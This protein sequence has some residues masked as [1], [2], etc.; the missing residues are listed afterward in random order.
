[1]KKILIVFLFSFFALGVTTTQ[2]QAVKKTTHAVKK[3]AKKVGNKTAELASK[4]KAKVTD[5]KVENKTGPNNETIY[6]TDDN[7]YYWV[8]K[9]GKRHF[10]PEES[11]KTKM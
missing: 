6:V 1:M 2:A 3:G 10:L 9:K 11:L 8:D 4:G 7:R 5:K